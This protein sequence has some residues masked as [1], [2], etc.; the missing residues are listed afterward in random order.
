MAGGD[1][2]GQVNSSWLNQ[3]EIWF[4]KIERDVIARYFHFR[5][6]SRPQT[7]ITFLRRCIRLPHSC[8]RVMLL[9]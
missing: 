5:K 9:L 1:C 4:S 6:G 8:D 3:V 2:R 7:A